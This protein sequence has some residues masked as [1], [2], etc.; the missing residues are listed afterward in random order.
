MISTFDN[1]E[2][3]NE[4]KNIV[5][6]AL[7]ND[8]ISYSIKNVKYYKSLYNLIFLYTNELNNIIT[9]KFMINYINEEINE[10]S[11]KKLIKKLDKYNN[12]IIINDYKFSMKDDL[13]NIEITKILKLIKNIIKL[14]NLL[15][16]HMQI[17]NEIDIFDKK[18]L[19]S[20]TSKN[21]I[22][23][24]KLH[25]LDIY[26]IHSNNI[27]NNNIKIIDT[28][29]YNINLLIIPAE[30]NNNINSIVSFIDSINNY[31][32]KHLELI[33]FYILFINSIKSKND[34]MDDYIFIINEKNKSL[35]LQHEL[36]KKNIKYNSNNVFN[37]TFN[38]EKKENK[39]LKNDIH[40]I[41][42]NLN[43]V[44]TFNKFKLDKQY[45]SLVD[46]FDNYN[47]N[48]PA[49]YFTNSD[50]KKKLDNINK[51]LIDHENKNKQKVIFVIVECK[52]DFISYNIQNL[53]NNNIKVE[54]L[55]GINEN[56]LKKTNTILESKNDQSDNVYISN[57][58][59]INI[60]NS[61]IDI[62]NKSN[63]IIAD[64]N[65]YNSKIILIHTFDNKTY[66]TLSHSD[67]NHS[68][69]FKDIYS[70]IKNQP[71]Y[72]I[73]NYNSLLESNILNSI[74]TKSILDEYH[75]T[76]QFDIN[77]YNL[78]NTLQIKN[79]IMDDIYKQIKLKF[80][81]ENKNIIVDMILNIIVDNIS[82][83][84]KNKNK[85]EYDSETYM[86]YIFSVSSLMNKFKKDIIDNYN[87]NILDN[88]DTL[89]DGIYNKILKIN[90]NVVDKYY[91]AHIID[92]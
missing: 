82:K 65:S 42:N 47:I 67:I 69:K 58:Q 90:D 36:E 63:S 35:L 5:I 19:M 6:D 41:K 76:M 23:K 62:N 70:L 84:I 43:I 66:N 49:K 81:F 91:Y 53:L 59:K 20:D 68:I 13:K 45:L 60:I 8:F 79:S 78:E 29:I 28:I 52:K 57:I 89:I 55:S 75:K 64:Y 12:S 83:Y 27:N 16:Y 51:V 1:N 34:I 40:T 50:S 25:I 71:N 14:Y 72:N 85:I 26:K 2:N 18:I 39:K 3:I 77:S 86:T 46:L 44:K 61:A 32:H 48:A 56:Y 9:D 87:D 22:N 21:N 37:L 11:V 24:N 10:E 17:I 4:N 33:D 88:L 30:F 92:K 54:K 74:E 7:H 38:K 31:F 15:V 73:E 80:T